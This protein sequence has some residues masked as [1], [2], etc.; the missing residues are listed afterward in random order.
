M[1]T[2]AFLDLIPVV[3]YEDIRVGHDFLVDVLGFTSAGLVEDG[4]G[5][6]IHGEVRA[7]DQRIFAAAGGLTTPRAS[8]SASGGIVVHVADVDAHFRRTPRRAVPRSCAHPPTRTKGSARYAIQEPGGSPLVRHNVPDHV[9]T[10]HAPSA[11]AVGASNSLDGVHHT[12]ARTQ[13]AVRVRAGRPGAALGDRRRHR[14]PAVVGYLMEGDESG[15]GRGRGRG[16]GS[17]H[18]RGRGGGYDPFG[19]DALLTLHVVLGG[20][21]LVLAIIRLVWRLTTPLPPWAPGWRGSSGRSSTGP[22]WR[23]TS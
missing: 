21:I 12:V 5:T 9:V 23:S 10:P 6:V 13:R 8:G 2:T 3:P 20:T 19:D 11:G 14:R 4:E 16:G 17:G 22:S 15:R 7:G 1:A 18:G